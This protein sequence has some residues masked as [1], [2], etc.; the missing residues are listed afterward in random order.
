MENSLIAWCHH[1]LNFWIGCTVVSDACDNCYARDMAHH[2]RWAEWGD[3]PRRRT[4]PSTW[5]MAF[6][7]NRKVAKRGQRDRVFTNSLSDFFDN[8]VPT[9]W[10]TEAWNVIR[11]CPDMDWLILTKRPQ[12]IRKMLP[13]DW[14]A[15]FCNVWLGVTAENMI[16][17]QRRIPVLLRVPAT[18]HFLSCEPL[19]EPLDLRRWLVSGGVDWVICGG[20]SGHHRRMMEPDWARHLRDQCGECGVAFFMKQMT[21]GKKVPIPDDLLVRL[22]PVANQ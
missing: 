10:R 13:P 21:G 8:K 9:E 12:N 22:F 6:T 4:A 3:H 18:V 15:G 5:K 20:E 19:L 14:D 1:T 2:Y 7:L 17:A 16:E 11:A